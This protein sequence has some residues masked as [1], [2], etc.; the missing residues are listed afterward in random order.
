MSAVMDI[1]RK[2]AEELR[3]LLADVSGFWFSPADTGPLVAAFARHRETCELKL[4]EKISHSSV[5]ALPAERMQPEVAPAYDSR[6]VRQRP[7]LVSR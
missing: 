6:M 4:L 7:L 1:D 2:A 3:V 5:R